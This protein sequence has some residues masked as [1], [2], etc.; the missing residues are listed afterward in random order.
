MAI[1]FPYPVE[2]NITDDMAMPGI[3]VIYGDG[4]K[5]RSSNGLKIPKTIWNIQCPLADKKDQHKLEDFIRSVGNHTSFLWKSPRDDR[6]YLYFI[7][8]KVEGRYRLGG[9]D[10][11]DFFVRTMQFEN[12]RRVGAN[13]LPSIA[14]ISLPLAYLVP[15]DK[16]GFRVVMSRARSTNT[17]INLYQIPYSA[18]TQILAEYNITATILAGSTSVFVRRADIPA[19]FASFGKFVYS[20]LAGTGYVLPDIT[21]PELLLTLEITYP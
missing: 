14:Q 6:P 7:T 5:S 19:N 2:A 10:K 8:G 3:A 13:T 18:Y 17:I 1:T 12:E 16:T 11:K 4:H 20:I 9:G 21:R 15:V